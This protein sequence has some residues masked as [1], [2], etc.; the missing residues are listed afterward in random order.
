MNTELF[1]LVQDIEH[2][3]AVISIDLPKSLKKKSPARRC[4]VN[5][6]ELAKLLFKYRRL[7]CDLGLK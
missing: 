5:S 4:R 2:L 3:L 7:T 6:I 1:E